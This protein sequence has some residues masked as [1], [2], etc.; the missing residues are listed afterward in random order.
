MK[1]CYNTNFALPKQLK[2]LDP[3]CMT[4]LDLW[5]CFLKEIKLRLITEEIRYIYIIH[6]C[7]MRFKYFYMYKHHIPYK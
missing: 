7:Y 3:S 2:D 5:D 4:D 6:A 1:F